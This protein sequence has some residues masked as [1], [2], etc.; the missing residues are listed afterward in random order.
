MKRYLTKIVAIDDM[1]LSYMSAEGTIHAVF[2]L[3]QIQVEYI[4]RQR[5]LHVCFV[6][7]EKAFDRVPRKVVEWAMR[8]I[9][10]PEALVTT[11]MSL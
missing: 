7:Q 1:Q 11:V 4:A 8:M 9:G 3:K 5:K 6:D 2:I 10:F